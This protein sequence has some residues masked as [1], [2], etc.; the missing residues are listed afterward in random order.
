MSLEQGLYAQVVMIR[1]S[2]LDDT[3]E[4]YKT[5]RF[6]FQGQSA[7]T[8]HQF[9]LDHK[10]LKETFMAHEPY[11]YKIYIKLNLGVIKNTTIKHLE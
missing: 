4:K 1:I 2:N 9:D 5:K 6:N 10:W 8:K 11:F 3:K 7:I